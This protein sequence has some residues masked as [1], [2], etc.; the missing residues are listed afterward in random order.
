MEF[1]DENIYRGKKFIM[2][3][4]LS[5]KPE[6]LTNILLTSTMAYLSKLY[7]SLLHLLLCRREPG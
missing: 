6:K 5:Q 7:F 2:N 4:V 3:S 1:A